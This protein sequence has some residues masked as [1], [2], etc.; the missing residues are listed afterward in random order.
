MS[1]ELDLARGHV[2][3]VLDAVDPEDLAMATPCSGWEV[4]RVLAHLAD[5]ADVVTR[6][7]ET[8]EL[9][10]TESARGE[11]SDPVGLARQRLAAM[12]AA[13]SVAAP[14]R[15]AAARLPAL[16]ELTVH[17]WD[18]GVALDPA[19]RVPESLAAH[20]LSHV[21]TV[22]VGEA[23]GDRFAAP[24]AVPD[25]APASDRLVA[26]LGRTPPA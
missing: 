17:G 12:D 9:T 14:D 24:L 21:E 5:S 15:A 20:V 7:L 23:R 4:G 11:V 22:L 16:V 3:R 6:L 8:G 1:D 19:H 2:R 26:F 13:L 10:Y 18:V 25:D